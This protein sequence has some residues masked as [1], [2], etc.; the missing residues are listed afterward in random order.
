MKNIVWLASY[1]KSGNTWFRLFLQVLLTNTKLNINTVD[2]TWHFGDKKIVEDALDL[3]SDYL[4]PSKVDEFR[5]LAYQYYAEQ[6]SKTIFVKIHDAYTYSAYDHL[7]IVPT[8]VSKS[9]IYIVR[10]PLDVS[11]SWANHNGS[12]AE[13]TINQMLNSNC[14]LSSKIGFQYPQMIGTWSRHIDTWIS[15]QDIPVHIVKYED[16]KS[17]PF[18][19]FKSAVNSIG[20]IYTDEEI[21]KAINQT[22]FSKL[23]DQER[24]NGFRENI[25]S[26][27]SFFFRGEV[28]RWKNELTSEQIDKIIEANY[29]MMKRFGYI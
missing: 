22:T 6:T 9:V 3:E 12:T 7:Q 2:S 29:E 14:R 1:P 24:T 11:L 27:S 18:E 4:S 10:N 13:F 15:Q 28:G 8:V 16:M 26:E 23:K 25:N 20:L 21:R 17:K 5:R 19:T